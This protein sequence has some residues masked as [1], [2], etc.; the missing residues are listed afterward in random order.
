ML[1]ADVEPYLMRKAA[2]GLRK[3]RRLVPELIVRIADWDRKISVHRAA[4]LSADPTIIPA[5]PGIYIFRDRTGYLYIGESKDLRQRLTQHLHDSDRQ[6][7]ANYLRRSGIEQATVEIHAFP[8]DSRARHVS[9]RR[10][11]ESSLIASRKPK[12]NLRP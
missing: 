6:S 2:F 11:Y 3:N 8:K 7:L 5:T 9:V 10:A 4:V 1:A 12:F